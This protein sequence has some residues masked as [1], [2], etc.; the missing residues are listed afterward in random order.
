[1]LGDNTGEKWENKDGQKGTFKDPQNFILNKNFEF[2][3]KS[4][5]S[6]CVWGE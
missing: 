6:L 4:G 2:F 5:I 1:M 3:H